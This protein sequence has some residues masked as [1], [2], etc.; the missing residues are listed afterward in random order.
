MILGKRTNW[1]HGVHEDVTYVLVTP[2]FILPDPK[3]SWFAHIDYTLA[4]DC[5][6]YYQVCAG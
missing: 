1:V 3:Y 5:P 4:P 2:H 6:L